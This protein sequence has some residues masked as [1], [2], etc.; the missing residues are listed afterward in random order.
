MA[1]VSSQ[2][3][4]K[5]KVEQ[6]QSHF[7]GEGKEDDGIESGDWSPDN[8]AANRRKILE[9]EQPW[10]LRGM[11]CSDYYDQVIKPQMEAKAA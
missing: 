10:I 8:I 1:G 5:N 3:K 2:K 4:F 11:T 7:K 6:L 9:R